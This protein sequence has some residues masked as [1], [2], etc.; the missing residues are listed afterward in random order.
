MRARRA[1]QVDFG[2]GGAVYVIATQG[3]MKGHALQPTRS[4]GHPLFAR[5]GVTAEPHVA[6]CSLD[7]DEGGR[8]DGFALVVVSDGVGDV[9]AEEAMLN[10][11]AEADSAQAAAVALVEEAAS[12]AALEGED[13]DDASAVVVCW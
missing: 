5:H 4:L 6:A 11:V 9:L 2:D 13:R 1:V 7:D 12:T 8:G 3:E 10:I